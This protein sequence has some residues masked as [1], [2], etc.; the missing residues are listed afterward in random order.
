MGYR[1]KKEVMGSIAARCRDGRTVYDAYVG[2]DPIT[3]KQRRFMNS[4][5]EKLKRTVEEFYSTI[6]SCGDFGAMLKPYEIMDARKA[7][8]LLN[9]AGRRVTLEQ[10]VS[11]YVRETNPETFDVALGKAFDEYYASFGDEQELH[12]KAV[13]TRVGRF[14][15][16]FGRDT[17]CSGVTAKAVVAWLNDNCGASAKTYNNYLTYIRTFLHWCAKSERRYVKSNPLVDVSLKNV[18][19][20]EP[21]YLRA[22]DAAKLFALL[23]S[24]KV[25]HPEYLVY[26]TLSFFCGIRREEILRMATAPDA[27]NVN[28]E[29]ETIRIAKPKGWTKGIMPRAFH[30]VKNA[31]CWLRAVPYEESVAKITEATTRQIYALAKRHGVDVPKNAGRHTFITMHVALHGEP[32]KTEAMV[33]TSKQMRVSNYCGLASRKEGEAYF[34]ILPSALDL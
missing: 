31:L 23:E 5:I 29:D 24:V 3:G 18:A 30:P 28:L 34:A 16:A 32:S 22:G 26:A 7:Y 8:D 12:R 4:D 20:K 1:T 14:V 13:R 33:G 2:Y 25:A 15:D 17:P 21:E 11:E 9:K 6:K 10:V 27:A 19:Y